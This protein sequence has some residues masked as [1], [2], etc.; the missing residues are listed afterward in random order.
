MALAVLIKLD[1]NTRFI[2]MHNAYNKSLPGH[3]KRSFQLQLKFEFELVYFI[4]T[5]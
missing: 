4:Q 3:S 5:V 2:S 1:F